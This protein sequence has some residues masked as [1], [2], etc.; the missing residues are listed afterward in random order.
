[1][2]L[3]EQI[4]DK[5]P[6]DGEN[7]SPHRVNTRLRDYVSYRGRAGQWAWIL[8]RITGLGVLL[9]VFLHIIDTSLIGW[10]PCAYNDAIALY[11]MTAFRIGEIILVGA[12]LYH[13]LNGVRIIIMDFWP[14]TTVLQKKLLHGVVVVFV[15]LYVPAIYFMVHWMITGKP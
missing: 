15:V 13:A 4:H 10:G 1:M 5:Q 6:S 7:Y 9:F 14:Q 3:S 11:R 2:G 8:H 12:I